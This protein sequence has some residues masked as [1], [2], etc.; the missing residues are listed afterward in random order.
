LKRDFSIHQGLL[1]G[2]D[3]IMI[4]LMFQT[5][6]HAFALESSL[7]LL[8]VL[9]LCLKLFGRCIIRSDALLLHHL[10]SL[11]LLQRVCG[12]IFLMYSE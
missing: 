5:D 10:G 2:Y 8:R 9:L 12:L 1:P 7:H 4:P 11:M 3:R 6:L